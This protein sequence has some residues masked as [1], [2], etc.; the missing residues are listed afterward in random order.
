M[1]S[2]VATTQS[3]QCEY[4]VG[5]GASAGGLAAL[6]EL[7]RATPSDTAAA[8]VVIQHLS[9]D[10]ESHMEQL[11]GRV[12]NFT[13][14]RVEHGVEVCPGTIYLIPPATVM[15]ISG[16]QLLLTDRP[17]DEP[18]SRPID[19]FFRS[20]ALARNQRA[21][22]IVLSGTG[23]DG[24][25]GVVDIHGE[26]GLVLVQEPSTAEFDGMPQ[27]AMDTA[28]AHVVESPE[29]L[30][31][32]VAAYIKGSLDPLTLAQRE[33]PQVAPEALTVLLDALLAAHGVD[34]SDYKPST[35]GRR[36]ERRQNLAGCATFAEYVQLA[37][38]NL[39]E[40]SELYGD[41]GDEFEL[42]DSRGRFS[43]KERDVNIETDTRY[44]RARGTPGL[45]TTMPSDRSH[46][47]DEQPTNSAALYEAL[48]A[49]HL[50]P[51][52]LVDE[53]FKVI[54]MFGGVEEFLHLKGGEISTNLLDLVD[55]D[56]R[57]F[58]STAMRHARRGGA[59]VRY[60]GV[61]VMTDQGQKAVTIT[62]EPVEPTDTH[63]GALLIRLEAQ[64]W[65]SSPQLND[66]ALKL[67][68]SEVTQQQVN[69]LESELY[70]AQ[71]NLQSRVEELE[72]ANEELVASNE[73]RQSTNEELRSVNEQLRSA[74]TQREKRVELLSRSKA[75]M[76][77]LLAV[78]EVG[79]IFVDE[80]LEIRRF[81]PQIADVFQLDER[82]LGSSLSALEHPLS[83]P[84]LPGVV[85]SVIDTGESFEGKVNDVN[86]TP[87]LMRISRYVRGSRASGAVLALSD[88]AS[89]EEAERQVA[90]FQHIVEHSEDMYSLLNEDGRFVYGNHAF[91]ESIGVH[92]HQFVQMMIHEVDPDWSI[93]R[94]RRF[95]DQTH[96]SG[97]SV[98]ESSNRTVGG[99]EFP[100]EISVTPVDYM[101]E[102]LLWSRSRD[103][104]ARKRRRA[105]DDLVNGI[106][107]IAFDSLVDDEVVPKVL[108]AL[109]VNLEPLAVEAWV[110]RASGIVDAKLQHIY[111]PSEDRARNSSRTVADVKHLVEDAVRKVAEQ[112]T[113][114]G[115]VK[116]ECANDVGSGIAAQKA[117]A[118]A[119]D[120]DGEQVIVFVIRFDPS[121]GIFADGI[122]STCSAAA[123]ALSMLF[124]RRQREATLRLRERAMAASNDAIMIA[125][126]R[127][128][129]FSLVYVNSGF[130]RISGFTATEAVGQ[131]W[132]ILEGAET[133]SEVK[134]QI[135]EAVAN[136]TSRRLTV[137]Y[138]R[139]DGTTYWAELQLSP[140]VDEDQQVRHFVAVLHDIT[141]RIANEQK[142]LEAQSQA[143]SANNAK[144]RFLATVGHDIR[145]PLTAIIGF[146][147]AI[148]RTT[149]DELILEKLEAIGRNADYLLSLIQDI[150]E[151]AK[152]EAGKLPVAERVVDL[153][154]LLEDTWKLLD[155]RFQSRSYP[156][157]FT[158]NDSIPRRIATDGTRLRQILI[159]LIGNAL[160]FTA[161]GRVE[162]TFFV[163][164]RRS[165]ALLH[166]EVTDTGVGIASTA[167]DS[168]FDP[169]SR[170]HE[171]R[172]DEEDEFEGTGLGLSIVKGLV[173]ALRGKITVQSQLGLGTKFQVSLPI[174]VEAGSLD[175]DE[176]VLHKR[177]EL[178]DRLDLTE[179]LSGLN[180][181]VA[182][183]R[184]D[185]AKVVEFYL[186]DAG[187]NVTTVS[188]GREAVDE[189]QRAEPLAEERYDVLV[190]DMQMPVMDGYEAASR[191]REWGF[192]RPIIA[193]SAGALKEDQA[194]CIEVG[195]NAFLLKPA[196][197]E[198]LIGTVA[199]YGK[200]QSQESPRGNDDM[201]A[202][203]RDA[204][205]E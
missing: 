2:N 139:R 66:E 96:E 101:G 169:F 188:N 39:A 6:T 81:T 156:L 61:K 125:D 28:M 140:V 51:S 180:I 88:V 134:L 26:G 87:Y 45:P 71:E 64:E 159:N 3:Q 89:L 137:L 163:S 54:H 52:V 1:E 182:D 29:M 19:V 35:I 5:V 104:S 91:C 189:A 123:R 128:D 127:D 102:K 42:L 63:M 55:D 17:T 166:V 144:T 172:E 198:T 86:G 181:L 30:A 195:C 43:S 12:A 44:A 67:R 204:A 27:S 106:T 154:A 117:C 193:L 77:N 33:L 138:Y 136:R 177:G 205:H 109:L 149:Q 40:L 148:R 162:A 16:N 100:V 105:H 73:E 95:F 176:L 80:Q 108:K 22:G 60:A 142:L 79:V 53:S 199:R 9:P 122:E 171:R 58:L 57:A 111:P 146:T 11:L 13:F 72:T 20:L 34:F 179:A 98:F 145:S 167:L 201:T 48:L 32:S 165:K 83:V 21:V 56:L 59:P 192:Q 93:D 76:D 99:E 50:P 119:V 173:H 92:A 62:A 110:G 150:L 41:L 157:D 202:T 112:H 194:R 24:A 103:I 152:I 74:N 196:D 36:I 82:D 75:D 115:D 90:R 164:D 18:L 135:S 8:F 175:C 126:A 187:A 190:L 37:T 132:S 38:E 170:P 130:E 153:P 186:S 116:Q 47:V 133:A 121:N 178:R 184:P 155:L 113:A 185:V 151:I 118:F 15:I 141:D 14:E 124:E 31:A 147:D 7:F 25:R 174:S 97:G 114:L 69:E 78:T 65:R 197:E 23:S 46:E 203:D 143:V 120:M 94:F 158:L 4:V 85:Q 183:D 68:T 131:P 49:R 70:E 84:D 107:R 160:K 168:I 10:F 129:S 191:L 161:E 200:S